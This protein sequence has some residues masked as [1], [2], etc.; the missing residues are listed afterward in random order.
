M[1]D[2]SVWAERL[3]NY[4][5]KNGLR[6][7]N[8]RKLIAETFFETEGHLNFEQLYEAVRIRDSNVGQA[9]VYRTLKVL[10]ESGLANSS[11]FG[12]NSALY[13][14]AISDDHHDHLICTECGLIIEF[15]DDEIEARQ[16][17]VAKQ[18]GFEIKDHTMELYGSCQRTNAECPKR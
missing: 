15:C 13:E 10:V 8:Q 17:A 18:N 14:P 12:G 11:R 5:S 16:N 1:S 9:T 7:T 2:D 6:L 4:L 3:Q